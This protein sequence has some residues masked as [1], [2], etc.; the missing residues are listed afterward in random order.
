MCVQ[1][2]VCD[3]DTEQHRAGVGGKVL[4]TDTTC[5]M[6]IMALPGTLKALAPY[7]Q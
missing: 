4:Y 6:A 2:Y 1:V 7:C 3:A 5:W